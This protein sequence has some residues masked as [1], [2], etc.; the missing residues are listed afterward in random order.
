MT[1]YGSNWVDGLP[2]C[3][4]VVIFQNVLGPKVGTDH[5]PVDIPTDSF[6]AVAILLWLL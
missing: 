2:L 3:L 5:L 6:Y 1:E 4:V